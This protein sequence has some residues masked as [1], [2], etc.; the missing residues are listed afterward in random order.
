MSS[1]IKRESGALNPW[2]THGLTSLVIFAA[3]LDSSLLVIAFFSI[4]PSFSAVSTAE[5]SWILNAYT[6][7]FGALLVP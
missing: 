7:V 5:L 4:G 3:F 2:S 6:I 1:N